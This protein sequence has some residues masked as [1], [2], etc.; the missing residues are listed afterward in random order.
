MKNKIIEEYFEEVLTPKLKSFRISDEDIYSAISSVREQMLSCIYRWNDLAFRNTILF[1][2][3]EEGAYYLPKVSSVVRNF[4]VVTLRNSAIETIHSKYNQN[5]TN[6]REITAAAL[7]YFRHVDF[8]SISNSIVEFENDKYGKLAKKY[9]IIWAALTE[10]ANSDNNTVAY[11]PASP[12][13][14]SAIGVGYKQP[15]LAKMSPSNIGK[16]SLSRVVVE[17]GYSAVLNCELTNILKG[18]IAQKAPLVIDGFKTLSRN[19]DVFLFVAEHL[20]SNGLMLI[21]TNYLIS[22]GYVERRK[23]PLRPG[24]TVKEMES[25]ALNEEGISEAHKRYLTSFKI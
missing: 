22:N 10:L 13:Q 24:S 9:P 3:E 6:I 20:L 12:S 7:K 18:A 16:D 11:N 8:A 14:L 4:I 19:V 25:N 21:T 5:D 17:D 15:I 2:G 23:I 1:I